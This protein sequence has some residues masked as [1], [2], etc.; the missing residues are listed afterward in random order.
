MSTWTTAARDELERYFARLGPWLKA[1]GA[2]PA[3]VIEDL[4]EH[5]RREVEAGGLPV[6]TD[7][8]V[9]RLLA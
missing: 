2:D 6:V 8:D 1:T 9:R 4:R 7:G 3:E 5:L